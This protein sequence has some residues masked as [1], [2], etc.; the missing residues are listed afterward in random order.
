MDGLTLINTADIQYRLHLEKLEEE[1]VSSSREL[2]P[3]QAVENNQGVKRAVSGSSILMMQL[4]ADG[5]GAGI[6]R[7]TA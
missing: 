4:N 7:A 2:R 5:Y 6:V 1:A 3:L